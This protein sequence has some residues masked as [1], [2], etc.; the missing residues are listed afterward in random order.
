MHSPSLY[1]F[2]GTKYVLYACEL[3]V[4]ET[5]LPNKKVSLISAEHLRFCGSIYFW[6]WLEVMEEKRGRDRFMLYRGF[7]DELIEL[8][9]C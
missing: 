1:R 3:I 2:V 4:L 7:H 5:G 6:R 9:S 8:S